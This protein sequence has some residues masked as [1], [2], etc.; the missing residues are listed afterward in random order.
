MKKIYDIC[1]IS[2]PDY[3]PNNTDYIE[4]DMD[5]KSA[6]VAEYCLKF[7]KKFKKKII[8]SGKTNINSSDKEREEKF[9]EYNLKFKNFKI[10]FNDKLKFGSYK[11]IIQSE[12][13]VAQFQQC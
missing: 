10:S 13:I 1:V 6:L 9:Y 8:I 7:S 2:E 4:N 3:E 11:N 5:K 12:I